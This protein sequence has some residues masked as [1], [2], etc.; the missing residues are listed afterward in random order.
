MSVLPG[1]NQ[2]PSLES[3][4]N[5]FSH[6]VV[7]SPWDRAEADTPQ[8]HA[9][10]FDL[11][12]RLISAI[13]HTRRST[14]L[15]MHGVA[16][17]GKTHLLARLRTHL[18]SSQQGAR[19]VFISVR[20][21]CA[22][23]RM[24]RHFRRHLVDDL[25][26]IWRDST[27]RLQ[28]LLQDRMRERPSKQSFKEV[29]SD[30]GL[31]YSLAA[32]LT[33]YH[34]GSQQAECSAWLRG[35]PLPESVL[36][37]LGVADAGDADEEQMEE[38][39]QDM[40]IQLCQLAAPDLV[41][42]CFD[43]LECLESFSGD[44]KGLFAYGKLAS[45]LV[46]KVDHNA[47][48]I[49][50]IQ[51][52][53][54]ARLT[55]AIRG[56]FLDRIAQNRTDLHPLTRQQGRQLLLSRLAEVPQLAAIRSGDL[57]A[58]LWPLDEDVLNADPDEI[59][60]RK[61][62]HRAK[63]K[64]ET[65]RGKPA[66]VP[67]SLTESLAETFLSN[68]ERASQSNDHMASDD[69]LLKG[70]PAL[71]DLSG[72]N[73]PVDRDGPTTAST[74]AQSSVGRIPIYVCNQDN[75][76]ALGNRFKK[77]LDEAKGQGE[78]SEGDLARVALVRDRRREISATAVKCRERL[79]QLQQRGARL[80]QASPEVMAALDALRNM[81]ADAQ[82]GDVLHRGEPVAVAS[83]REWLAANVPAVLKEFLEEITE[84]GVAF[85][86]KLLEYVQQQ[87]IVSLDQ[88]A[89]EIGVPSEVI[90]GYVQRNAGKL[91]YLA[92][93]PAVLFHVVEQGSEAEGG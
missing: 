59:I 89:K 64:F 49:S 16:G 56:A 35:E 38:D 73:A 68:Q 61:L 2:R 75:M 13:A 20:M 88:A 11:C 52:V 72:K 57:S 42:F 39:A 41:I 77:I 14:S 70:L 76:N 23:T 36:S 66:P 7:T 28:L 26:R 4:P 67:L 37:S 15:L 22:P 40:V 78:G 19:T 82:A 18:Q 58:S 90:V 81:L 93:P 84:E 10:A 80:V 53:F 51:S 33:R 83:V 46:D 24:W 5:P 50:A 74:W 17:S 30:L 31:N 27:T 25:L 85:V 48:V 71:L 92:G 34:E 63:E 44:Q 91:V 54:V 43:Q 1:V 55:D 29:A 79:N 65:A 45:T 12:S 47:F 87:C 3:I 86:P 32:I 9:E 69:I 6:E 21:N 60:A 8:I 62:I